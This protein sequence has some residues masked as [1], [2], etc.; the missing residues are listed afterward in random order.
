[1][2]DVPDGRSGG[3]VLLV[4]AMSIAGGIVL[5]LG[6]GGG[7]TIPPGS[8]RAGAGVDGGKLGGCTGG[9][10]GAACGGFGSAVAAHMA[11]SPTAS[12]SK[13]L[14]ISTD[15]PEGVHWVSSQTP[16]GTLLP[17][18]PLHLSDPLL[19]PIFII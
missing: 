11:L 1:M 16:H 17:S 13:S 19:Q 4:V 7:V 5:V 15:V 9:E 18:A 3:G 2:M 6:G 10:D 8:S 14:A 12:Q